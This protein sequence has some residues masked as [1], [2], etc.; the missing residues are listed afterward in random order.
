MPTPRS[1]RPSLAVPAGAGR[2][3]RCAAAGSSEGGIAASASSASA[4]WP[5]SHAGTPTARSAWR[6]CG[7]AARACPEC[8][9]GQ[10]AHQ[11][12]AAAPS[13]AV[14]PRQRIVLGQSKKTWP[15]TP[16]AAAV[17]AASQQLAHELAAR[18]GGYVRGVS[19]GS[20]AR[21]CRQVLSAVGCTAGGNTDSALLSPRDACSISGFE[22]ISGHFTDFQENPGYGKSGV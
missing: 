4:R 17:S 14:R 3:R 7:R 1:G 2:S 11:R 20:A 15:I 6:S 5:S 19:L 21:S 10:Q 9:R 12:D 22:D 16:A 18:A 13:A 8:M